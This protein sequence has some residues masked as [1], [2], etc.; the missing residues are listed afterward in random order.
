MKID[1]R[2]FDENYYPVSK[3]SIDFNTGVALGLRVE[4]GIYLDLFFAS[5][6]IAVGVDGTVYEGKIGLKLT[7]DFNEAQINFKIYINYFGISF[8]F[9]IRLSIRILFWTK[10][11]KFGYELKYSGSLNVIELTFDLYD[12]RQPQLL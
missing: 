9:Y 8:E 12:K 3:L 4:G 1:Y 10:T 11:I 5:A 2:Y 7:F 6:S